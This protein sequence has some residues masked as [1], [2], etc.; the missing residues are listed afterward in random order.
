MTLF[1]YLIL[2]RTL[3]ILLCSITLELSMIIIN[4]FSYISVMLIYHQNCCFIRF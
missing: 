2:D 3:N 1:L 4:L